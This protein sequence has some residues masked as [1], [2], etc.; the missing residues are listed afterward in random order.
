MFVCHLDASLTLCVVLCRMPVHVI[1][2]NRPNEGPS[3]RVRYYVREYDSGSTRRS[4][5]DSSSA[6]EVSAWACC[7]SICCPQAVFSSQTPDE[8]L[9]H[10][11][12]SAL[13]TAK[14]LRAMSHR[15][16]SKL[17]C[18]LARSYSENS[19]VF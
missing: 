14:R 13:I 5:D 1:H 2:V 7:F 18:E 3:R 11:I 9:E 10:S 16:K 4:N 6:E 12:Q 17:S 15:M 19:L 8:D